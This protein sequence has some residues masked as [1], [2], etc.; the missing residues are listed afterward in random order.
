[1]RVSV[2]IDEESP[3]FT[4][5]VD[6]QGGTLIEQFAGKNLKEAT[7][8]WYKESESMP[9]EPPEDLPVPIEDTK[10]VW[11]VSGEDAAGVF[12]LVNIIATRT[13]VA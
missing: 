7:L 3:V 4:F 8:R 13:D 12:F 5:V 2:N 1:M 6:K 11:C 10:G 9:G